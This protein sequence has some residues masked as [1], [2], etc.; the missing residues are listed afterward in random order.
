MRAPLVLAFGL[1][2]FLACAPAPE[3][4]R[5]ASPTASARPSN[6]D[7]IDLTRARAKTILT[8]ATEWRAEHPAGACPSVADLKASRNLSALADDLDAWGRPFVI[9]CSTQDTRVLSVGPDGLEKNAD[10]IESEPAPAPL[11]KAPPPADTTKREAITND[12]TAPSFKTD[13][14]ILA[15]IQSTIHA[16][17]HPRAKECFD[18]TPG[19]KGA[20]IGKIIIAPDGTKKKGTLTSAGGAPPEVVACVG[21]AIEDTRFE[22]TGDKVDRVVDFK[23]P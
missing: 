21:H 15:R 4:A 2:G 6:N 17:V 11:S 18:K 12:P 3:G 10:D 23:Y 20:V 5:P 13:D 9:R 1:F 16:R 19:A 7:P 8:A 14:P 22:A